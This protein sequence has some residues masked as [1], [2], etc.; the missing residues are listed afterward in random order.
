[1]KIIHMIKSAKN[2][3]LAFL[4]GC[5]T[6]FLFICIISGCSKSPENI[7][8]GKVENGM[9]KIVS[10]GM[11]E[12]ERREEA[13]DDITE[14]FEYEIE[15]KKESF[16]ERIDKCP[17][18]KIDNYI[19]INRE[20]TVSDLFQAGFIIKDDK[21]WQEAEE[22]NFSS[23][24]IN[25]TRPE[26]EE[27]KRVA[28]NVYKWKGKTL[29]E[30]KFRMVDTYHAKVPISVD[31]LMNGDS[32]ENAIEVLGQ[33]SEIIEDKI[34]DNIYMTL[35]YFGEMDEKGLSEFNVS[36]DLSKDKETGEFV[37]TSIFVSFLY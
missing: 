21:D 11:K 24:V 12:I 22:G 14:T 17:V 8:L 13:E 33:P 36:V 26:W 18:Y 2:S 6:G 7:Q 32:Y 3:W 5:A 27:G 28:L 4:L 20:T 25:F 30:Q 15:T 1:M 19:E 31:G 16:N 9:G 10:L 23:R 34:D 35:K 37:I 29:E